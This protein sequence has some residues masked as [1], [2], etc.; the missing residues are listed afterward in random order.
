MALTARRLVCANNA[1]LCLAVESAWV[2][3]NGSRGVA[4]EVAVVR[5]GEAV[6][7]PRGGLAYANDAAVFSA[8]RQLENEARGAGCCVRYGFYSTS[9]LQAQSGMLALARDNMW[10]YVRHS[11]PDY[12]ST[13]DALE[14]C[15]IV[16]VVQEGS[17]AKPTPEKADVRPTLATEKRCER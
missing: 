13:G 12:Y 15:E 6:A 9:A 10:P 8:R 3:S 5:K 4:P 11:E 14:G 17:T 16:Y 2:A 7:R 1:R